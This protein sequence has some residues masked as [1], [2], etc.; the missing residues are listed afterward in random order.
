M[1]D[2]YTAIYVL[3]VP[4]ALAC[5][6]AFW[7]ALLARKGGPLHV[8]VGRLF[9]WGMRFV[10]LSGIAMGLMVLLDPYVRGGPAVG[11]P[12][13]SVAA[14]LARRQV[15]AAMILYLGVITFFPVHHGVRVIRTRRDPARLA[16]RGQRLLAW[17]PLA[18]SFAAV[19]VSLLASP[20]L[21]WVLLGMS[22]I[23]VVETV[24]AQRYLANPQRVRNGW[25]PEHMAFMLIAGIAAHTAFAVFFLGGIVGLNLPGPLALLPWLAPTLVGVPT[26]IVW[27]G[28]E[29][30]RAR[31]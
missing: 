18:A 25:R 13:A 24:L 17:L 28:R 7:V 9:G 31:A 10:A 5:L 15:F 14:W 16:T 27:V 11:T 2:L 30:R 26:I 3:H 12:E 21:P 22:P 4:V 8:R 29:V 19:A 20:G 1:S 23:G 6:P